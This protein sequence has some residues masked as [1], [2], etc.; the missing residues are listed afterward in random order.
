M[1]GE[2]KYCKLFL[3]DLKNKASYVAGFKCCRRKNVHP[4]YTRMAERLREKQQARLY[5]PSEAESALE[6]VV[7]RRLRYRIGVPLDE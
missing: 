2:K 6:R 7:D 4:A 1:Q 5:T 3:Y